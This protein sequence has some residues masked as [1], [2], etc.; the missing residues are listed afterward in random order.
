MRFPGTGRRLIPLFGLALAV[1]FLPITAHAAKPHALKHHV[2]KPR[3]LAPHFSA[4]VIDAVTGRVVSET[5]ADDPHYPASL[6]KM[7]TLYLVFD[8][9]Q[10]GRLKLDQRLPVSAHAANQSPTKL[11]LEAGGTIAVRDIILGLV[12]RSAN[13]AAVVAAEGLA[14]SEE[15]FAA[16]MTD[17]ARALGMSDTTY[18]NASGL[19]DPGQV[20]TARDIAVLAEALYR[21]FP[22][23]YH[24]FATESF[25][26]KGEVVTTHNHLMSQFA[27]MDG[28]KT[29]FIRA[30]GFNLA[31]SAVR[32]NWRLIG[33]V[34]GGTSAYSR[35]LQMAAL[36]NRTFAQGPGDTDIQL[37]DA[38]HQIPAHQI[39]VGDQLTP[40]A[41]ASGT[42]VI[43]PQVGSTQAA[44]IPASEPSLNTQIAQAQ[45]A[46]AQIAPV[47][48]AQA[49]TTQ[50]QTAQAQPADSFTVRAAQTLKHFSPI[51]RAEA[52]TPTLPRHNAAAGVGKW[53]IQVG[54]FDH[55]DDAQKAADSALAKLPGGA[56][57]SA[58][59][60]A[61]NE[62]ENSPYY[63]ALV[64]N[65]SAREAQQA[66]HLLHRAHRGCV[67]VSPSSL[68]LASR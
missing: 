42:L 66:C 49:Q 7:M 63:R 23:D 62:S 15:A 25:T 13:D 59:V 19:P 44:N 45:T 64:T 57:L 32:N 17:T 56:V 21:D 36:L 28:I 27:G 11:G 5:N 20:T 61:P 37:A 6:T 22:S 9:L 18:R 16:R 68:R 43:D 34:M 2:A 31:A 54:A 4:I 51:G 58:A 47:Q 38:A 33:V 48:S 26:Y 55:Q 35:D 50:A 60:V 46:Q 24:Y 10:Q 41:A 65:F 53:S 30:A 3:E 14:G 29:G 8:A 1:A 52:A 39:T 12:T 67:L 40:R